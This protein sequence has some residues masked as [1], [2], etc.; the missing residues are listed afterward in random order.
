MRGKVCFVAGRTGGLGLP[1]ARAL[2]DQGAIV[3]VGSSGAAR[4]AD[5][6]EVLGSERCVALDVTDEGSIRAAFDRTIERHSRLDVL[7]NAAGIIRRTPTLDMD[8]DEWE[9]LLRVNVTGTFLTSRA[10]AR[11]MRDQ[12]PRRNGERGCIL[13]FASISAFSGFM[14]AAAYGASKAAVVNMTYSFANDWARYGIRVNAVAPG[15]LPTELNRALV[16]GTPR[17]ENL[18]AHT[19]AARF[20]EPDEIVGAVT[21]L[22]GD[23]APFTTGVV[24]PVDG[25]FLARGVWA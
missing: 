1:L 23:S 20:G 22:C 15:V 14:D 12:E 13:H 10:A 3:M 24:L 25:G 8:V 21:Y 7:I 9:R 4:L 16:E 11:T 6:A 5:A 18:L 2:S 19:P 17:G